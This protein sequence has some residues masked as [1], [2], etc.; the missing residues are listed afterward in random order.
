MYNNYRNAD[1]EN[2]INKIRFHPLDVMVTGATGA[3]KSST[4]NSFFNKKV[5]RVGDGVDPETMELDAYSLTE[6]MRFW[7]TPGLGD[8]I[9]R[10]VEHAKKIT[11]LLN[12]THHEEYYF[13]DMVLII[14]EAGSRDIGT[15]IKLID[16]VLMKNFP[17]DRILVALNQADF[18]MKGN[19]WNET[20]GMP[21]STLVNYL[22][23]RA[24]SLQRRI[25]ESTGLN[26]CKPVYYSARYNY[27]IERLYDLIIDHMPNTPRRVAA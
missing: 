26:I 4:L 23:E 17:E 5:A 7:D 12:R 6:K 2:H 20:A 9:Q 1:I 13:L 18:A 8:G 3:G 19:H 15:A 22:E 11:E 14:V 24:M 10:D 25:R 16:Q 27:N 21:D